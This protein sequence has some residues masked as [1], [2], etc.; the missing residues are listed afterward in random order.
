MSA[1]SNAIEP[2]DRILANHRAQQAGFAD[3]VAAEHAGHFARLRGQRH[4]AQAPA[5]RRNRG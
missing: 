5:P 2:E 4:A 1:P 3:A